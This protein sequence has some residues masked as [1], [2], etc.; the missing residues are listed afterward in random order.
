MSDT[1]GSG[2]QEVA[3]RYDWAST[4]PSTAV[5]ETMSSVLDRDPSDV[6][7]LYASIDTDGLDA[8]IRSGDESA[9]VTFTY[10]ERA[11]TVY[12]TGEVVVQ[13]PD[14]PRR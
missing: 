12:G 4:P 11:V 13:P 3:V 9:A 5:V 14:S 7:Q 1:T 8:V 2:E 10:V 6:P